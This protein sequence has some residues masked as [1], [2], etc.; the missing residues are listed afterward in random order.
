MSLTDEARRVWADG[1]APLLPAGGLRRLLDA[2]AD[3]DPKLVQGAMCSPPPLMTTQDWPVEAADAVAYCFWAE[4][5]DTVGDVGKHF[6][7]T[8]YE[9]DKLL[10]GSS[11]WLVLSLWDD[12]P[13]HKARAFF[14]PLVADALVVCWA[15]AEDEAAFYRTIADNLN[16][17][18]PRL[19]LTD[20]RMDRALV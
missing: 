3:D 9:V 12:L 4:G 14:I 1:F 15:M 17:Q 19:A 8:C 11:C 13:R 16:D 7:R 5:A 18:A 20:W 6:A 10:G 2:L